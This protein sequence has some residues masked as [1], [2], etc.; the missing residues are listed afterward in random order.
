MACSSQDLNVDE[1][2][3]CHQNKA[4]DLSLSMRFAN[5][6]N[7]AQLELKRLSGPRPDGQV[8]VAVSTD[9]GE[10]KTGRFIS[11][12]SLYDVVSQTTGIPKT[13]KGHQVVCIYMRK[14]VFGEEGLRSTSIRN[15][16]LTSGNAV[17]RVVSREIDAH[18]Q[19]HVENL[20][21]KKPSGEESQVD[22][23]VTQ[24]KDSVS[25]F[26]KSLKSMATGLF[27]RKNSEEASAGSSSSGKTSSSSGTTSSFSGEGRTLQPT[28]AKPVVNSSN[29]GK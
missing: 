25:K 12:T 7:N 29:S 20:K 3:L 23:A 22:Q 9:A 18:G 15:L 10:R 16:G 26:G 27:E 19:A 8:T 13:K 11:S 1:Y 24:V 2:D 17:L 6:S 28:V 5:L 14:E 21:L 4:L